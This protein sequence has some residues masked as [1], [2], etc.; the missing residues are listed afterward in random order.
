[1]TTL[2][3]SLAAVAALA[4]AGWGLA[5]AP[6]AAAPLVTSPAGDFATLNGITS[7]CTGTTASP[8]TAVL[9]SNI[10]ATTS[11]LAIA[12][13]CVIT[14]DLAGFDLSVRSVNVQSSAYLTVDNTGSTGIL[15]ADASSSNNTPGIRVQSGSFLTLKANG[16]IATGGTNA[17][18]IGGGGGSG[19]GVIEIVGDD[20][21]ATGGPAN[22]TNIYSGGAGIGGSGSGGGILY[23]NV[24]GDRTIARGGG[25]AAGIGTGGQVS[26]GGTIIIAGDATDARS[27]GH[28]GAGIGGGG[29]ASVSSIQI[30][31][32]DT[33][34]YG[35]GGA[36]GIGS[37]YL[38]AS[39]FIEIS[40]DGTEAHG[41]LDGGAGIG[42]GSVGSATDNSS[43]TILLEG[44]G[45]VASAGGGLG[46]AIG[47]GSYA[48]GGTIIFQS[49]STTTAEASTSN[50]MAAAIGG[51]WGGPGPTG[52]G[53]GAYVVIYIGATVTATGGA[54][55]VGH[56][57]I[58]SSPSDPSAV[59]H[60]GSL[61]VDGT[62]RIPN[63]SDELRIPD[64][65]S[66]GPE[67]IVGTTGLIAGAIG[68]PTAGA[69][70][71]A[72]AS[73][74]RGQITNGGVIALS[75]SLVTGGSPAIDGVLANHYRLTFD[76]A[77]SVSGDPA[78]IT[79]FASTVSAGERTWPADPAPPA[80]Q[81]FEGWF[82]QGTS[83]EVTETTSLPSLVGGSPAGDSVDV[84]LEAH[85]GSPPPSSGGG[86]G[87]SGGTGSTGGTGGTGGWTPVVGEV[88]ATPT[89]TPTPTPSATP[90]P[91]AQPSTPASTPE[92]TETPVPEETSND[93][94]VW[95]WV[96]G[97]IAAVLLLILLAFLLL[98]RRS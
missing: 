30:V 62:L 41:G 29:Q 82:L 21:Q 10:S 87:G 48:S 75:A 57:H 79:L 96:V 69:E 8:D 81:V 23:I 27:N 53:E 28:N 80:G 86:S 40:G 90:E 13:G 63:A 67:L 71:R 55:V 36:A 70:I 68:T 18:G 74:S 26:T 93:V 16:T 98:R 61:V 66:G 42:S 14:V 52:E 31:G 4:L 46:A 72:V 59:G 89:P 22:G 2:S 25:A 78:D 56:G 95:P 17:A 15:T 91:T 24:S 83:Q 6:A 94:P 92:P 50:R 54:T 97:G 12:S 49:G 60:F 88:T 51:G 76:S 65:N 33:I 64:S 7:A 77:G 35:S 73:G 47:G 85:Y 43:A 1:M 5:A 19:A 37:G 32:D 11:T 3:R 34:A 58:A 9:T 45:T 20:T 44:V 84:A 39:T 38:R